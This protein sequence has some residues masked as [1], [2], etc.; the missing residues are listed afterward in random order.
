MASRPIYSTNE[1]RISSS[2]KSFTSLSAFD[3]LFDGVQL[4]YRASLPIIRMPFG[5]VVSSISCP[6]DL[7]FSMFTKPRPACASHWATALQSRSPRK[8][9]NFPSKWSRELEWLTVQGCPWW[10]LCSVIFLAPLSLNLHITLSW[11]LRI[12]PRPSIWTP[13]VARSRSFT[14]SSR[15]SAIEYGYPFNTDYL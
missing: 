1:Q 10:P 12:F 7:R 14:G 5:L 13:P 3:A 4:L 9:M 2:A 11:W 15:K 8:W 6:R